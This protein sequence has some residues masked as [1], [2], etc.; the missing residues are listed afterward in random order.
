MEGIKTA[1]P[2]SGRPQKITIRDE[3]HILRAV[4]DNRRQHLAELNAN[5]VPHASRST[6]KRVLKKHNIKKWTAAERPLLDDKIA[7]L[8]LE[9]AL[10][11]K[12]WD[13]EDWKKVV[14]SDECSVEKSADPRQV[15]VFRTPGEKWLKACISG[16]MKS[17]QCSL[18]VWGC[19]AGELKGT[20]TSI[21]GGITAEVYQS[22][23]EENLPQFVEEV[24]ETLGEEP[25]FM[26]DNAPVH[27]AHLVRNWLHG[28]D[29]LVM[30]WPPYSPD[31]NPIEHI[32]RKL[33]ILLQI[34]HPEIKHHSG[35]PE[36]VKDALAKALPAMWD[37]L[38]E[39]DFWEL[40]SSMPARVRA[41][42]KAN[43]WYTK[44]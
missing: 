3:R 25:I 21:R 35:R 39:K 11:Y 32:W 27:T 4:M 44:Y 12:D 6:L 19:F 10:R 33:K 14:W 23:L 40:S 17:G 22:V 43:G 42:I 1:Q 26:Q 29:Y 36:V 8:R 37:R 13:A 9:W 20:F 38:E 41:L 18:M 16:K 7:T 30:K 31:I 5:V 24:N 15:W 2:R 34:Y 28:E